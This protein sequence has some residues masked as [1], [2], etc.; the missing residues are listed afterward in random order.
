[1]TVSLSVEQGLALIRVDSP[2]VNGLSLAVRK[3]LL[4]AFERIR[5]RADVKAVV[6][7]GGG[8]G[9]S[10]GGDIR[11]LGTPAAATAPNLSRD[12]HPAI[13][14]CGKPVVAALHGFAIGG[15]LE[16]ALAC[17]YR[18]A[19]STTKMALPEVGLGMIPLSGTQRL[20]RL[21]GL[22]ASIDLMLSGR[23]FT[24]ADFAETGVFDRVTPQGEGLAAALALARELVEAPGPHP[25]VRDLAPPAK[26]PSLQDRRAAML[27]AGAPQAVIGLLD[28]VAACADEPDFE[29]GM[30]KA[31][32]IYDALAGSQT[33]R[34]ARDA[35]LGAAPA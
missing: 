10:A 26:D 24:A 25:L 5:D 17:H 1:M 16:T 2:P 34:E 35:F 14:F 11:E 13:E 15:G 6:L 20:P 4:W 28:A 8:R 12:V 31:R 18:V 23:T 9:F 19:E 7:T 29:A 21:L 32:A 27:A 30:A 22:A 33:A 3:G